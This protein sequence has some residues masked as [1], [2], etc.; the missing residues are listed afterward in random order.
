M[1]EQPLGAHTGYAFELD[2]DERAAGANG[3]VETGERVARVLEVVVDVADE[4]EIDRVRIELDRARGPLDHAQL[5]EPSLALLLAEM[6]EERG[7]DLDGVDTARRTD[8]FCEE[9]AEESG[10]GSDIRDPSTRRQGEGLRDLGAARVDVARLALETLDVFLDVEGFVEKRVVDP[11]RQ[12]ARACGGLGRV[13]R[14]TARECK[15]NRQRD[16]EVAEH[17]QAYAGARESAGR[18]SGL[19]RIG[20]SHLD[21]LSSYSSRRRQLLAP[22]PP[23]SGGGRVAQANAIHRCRPATRG[24]SQPIH[25][26]GATRPWAIA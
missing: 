24:P 11:L 6:L 26:I 18:P 21:S 8:A 7:R 1:L 17:G 3:A 22:S 9:E 4:G 19:R 16:Q 12:A 14:C 10:P 23:L 5:L 2:Q 15:G 20:V 13:R 25:F